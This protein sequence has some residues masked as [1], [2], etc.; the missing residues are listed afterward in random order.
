MSS[1]VGVGSSSA[2]AAADVLGWI[3]LSPSHG[4]ACAPMEKFS[5]FS[6]LVGTTLK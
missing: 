4:S 5:F 3:E 1:S 6:A 2:A